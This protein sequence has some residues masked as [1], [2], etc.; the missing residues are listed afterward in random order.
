[1]RWLHY[2]TLPL[3][4]LVWAASF[5]EGTDRDFSRLRFQSLNEQ[6]GTQFG[7][8]QSISLGPSNFI[9]F[10][11]SQGAHRYDGYEIV[12]YQ[13]RADDPR[14]LIDSTVWSMHLDSKKRFWMGTQKGVSRYLPEIDAFENYVLNP[15]DMNNNL[16]NRCNAIVEDGAG[17]VYASAEDG[18]IYKFDPA[19]N[20]FRTLVASRFGTIKSMSFDSHDTLWI[21][22]DSA[23]YSLNPE[24]LHTR[25]YV[26]GLKPPE[27]AAKNFIYS[28]LPDRENG[29]VWTASS[30]HGITLID[31]A[32]EKATSLAGELSSRRVHRLYQQDEDHIWA[33][34][35]GG[36]S[37]LRR[38]GTKILDHKPNAREDSLPRGSTRCMLIDD[39]QNFWIGTYKHGLYLSSNNKEFETFIPQNQDKKPRHKRV[40]SALL[41]DSKQRLWLGYV[42]SGI[43]VID[44]NGNPIFSLRNDANNPRALGVN[45][46]YSIF[47]DSL[48]QIWVGTYNGGLQ[49]FN[50]R[51]R[52]FQSYRHDPNDPTSIGGN[53]PRSIAEDEHGNLWIALK[54]AGI[55]RFDPLAE[56]FHTYRYN[57]ENTDQSLLDDWPSDIAVGPQGKIYVA[58][59]I[60][61]SILDPHSDTFKSLTPTKGANS[62]SNAHCQT[63]YFDKRGKLWVGTKDGLN[64]FRSETNT[65]TRFLPGKHALAITE[66]KSGNLWVGTDRGLAKLVRKTGDSKI[67]DTL[68]GIV[69]NSFINSS[70]A[71]WN[72]GTI[73][74]GQ[75]GG[76]TIFH[77]SKI[78][79]NKTPPPVFITDL[80]VFFQSLRIDPDSEKDSPLTKS[81]AETESINLDYHQKVLT[82]NFVAQNYIQPQ[83]NR[84]KYMLEGFDK[85]WNHV[86]TRREAKYTNLDPGNYVFR[87]Q[88]SNNDGY[89][90]EQGAQIAVIIN[91]PLWQ[92]TW[93]LA[94]ASVLSV[95]T[96]IFFVKKRELRLKAEQLRLEE[97]V[98]KRTQLIHEKNEE[99]A[100]QSEQL[101]QQRDELAEHKNLLEKRVHERTQ[102][103]EAA[104]LKAEQSDRLKS[105]FLA[106]LSHEIR[107]PLN[108][109]VGFSKLLQIAHKREEDFDDYIPIILDNSDSLLHLIDDILDFSL[110]ESDELKICEE[111]FPLRELLENLAHSHSVPANE[112]G[113]ELNFVNKLSNAD[114][115]LHSDRSRIKQ[116]IHNF[117]SNA[118]KFTEKGKVTLGVRIDKKELH[119]YVSD[120]GNG[121]DPEHQDAIFG[122]FIKLKEDEQMARRGVGLGLAISQSLAKLLGG[123]IE[124]QSTPGEGSIFELVLPEPE[125]LAETT[126]V[127]NTPSI[128]SMEEF[129][130]GRLNDLK[131]LVVEDEEP[132]FRYLEA[133]LKR[134]GIEV[135]WA[136]NGPLAV[137]AFN[138]DQ[139]FDL[140]LMDIKMPGMDG[141]KTKDV[142]RHKGCKVPI[143][144]QT[145]FAQ[146]E[147]EENIRMK[148]F[149]DYI[150][151]PIDRL[152]L[153]QKLDYWRDHSSFAG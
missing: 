41:R 83:K 77:P 132:N 17:N 18:S 32:T 7:Q 45:A 48:G 4:C 51:T 91:P 99:L 110:I 82:F 69:H 80:Q 8:I 63:L 136:K 58:T 125:L 148:K 113:L 153:Y 146:K 57:P 33:C 142:L 44:R 144:A 139:T 138:A 52:D 26:E 39:Q 21:G 81:I 60:G 78:K 43:D 90:N 95:L 129:E 65:F 92:R 47:E 131:V 29:V 123:R 55:S 35:G 74:F 133:A 84:Y 106:N 3:I 118:V 75:N 10:G 122:R 13:A 116:I 61:L 124:L 2:T 70:V 127:Q 67:Y 135:E 6:T 102:K 37:L 25:K 100:N 86:G 114:L 54:G 56:T 130:Q 85:D 115:V 88:A 23:L 50:E 15:V 134:C 141:F 16:N 147:D 73:T 38:D 149:D 112:K 96:I 108:A 105:S 117:L 94:T 93:F 76:L 150:A 24:T 98:E 119:I 71:T 103:L 22:S 53:D 66:D 111:D 12:S 19:A 62:L 49:K 145:A 68:D 152:V 42:D 128:T 40:V 104:M 59:P 36:T 20:V 137:E 30:Y 31:I 9:W 5:A 97:L 143:I 11:T 14:S 79:D 28:L 121:I 34:H 107:T 89:W 126:T 87:V 72:D 64:L 27:G 120:T 46:V 140:V 101:I 1:M 109:I 151:K